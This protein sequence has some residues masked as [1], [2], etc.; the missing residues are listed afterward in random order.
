MSF[1]KKEIVIIIGIYILAHALMLIVTGRWWDDWCSIG[2]D[3]ETL[4]NDFFMPMGR[5]DLLW[6]FYF[7]RDYYR[8]FTFFAF[9]VIVFCW[10]Y[11]LRYWLCIDKNHRFWICLLLAT[12]PFN[13]ARIVWAVFPYTIGYLLFSL[14]CVHLTYMLFVRN[15]VTYGQRIFDLLLFL[16][17]FTLN[18]CLVYYAIVL[19]ML[20]KYEGEIFNVRRY[21]KYFDYLLLPVVFFLVKSMFFTPYGD[22]QGYNAVTLLSLF[23]SLLESP[24]AIIF[25]LTDIFGNYFKMGQSSWFSLSII[26]LLLLLIRNRQRIKIYFRG[27]IEESNTAYEVNESIEDFRKQV[28]KI[29]KYGCILLGLALYSYVVIR[30][31]YRIDTEGLE[32]RDSV[33]VGIGAAMLVYAI[34]RLCVY[35]RVAPYVLAFLVICG[36]SYFVRSYE[37]YQLNYY[38]QL[39]FQ[40]MLDDNKKALA[41]ARNI[42]VIDKNPD[43]YGFRSVY[44]LNSNAEK[45]FN[46]Q[47]KL[48]FTSQEQILSSWSKE[49]LVLYH[50]KDYDILHK[51]IDVICYYSFDM[52]SKELWKE[53]L[54]EFKNRNNVEHNLRKKAKM[55][56]FSKSDSRYREILN[57][58]GFSKD[59]LAE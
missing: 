53:K 39:A 33:L 11:I 27:S 22:Y 1:T 52:S 36:I 26:L 45:V 35:K 58:K 18:S 56:V 51:K 29:G 34:V 42:Y 23:K 44:V 43:K 46:N 12:L 21:I 40:Y 7:P 48:F 37:A 8:E 17:S 31:R 4:F 55:M 14:A 41:D 6:T 25:V 30:H 49:M 20:Y 50:M 54:E 13:D 32:G 10:N 2:I 19:M 9:G 5:P 24:L 38:K 3:G 59:Y 15:K 16:C 57:D 28:L 47:D